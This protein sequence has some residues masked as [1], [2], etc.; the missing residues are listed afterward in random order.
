MLITWSSCVRQTP[1][2]R[3]WWRWTQQPRMISTTRT[4]ATCWPRKASSYPTRRWTLTQS[5]WRLRIAKTLC[6]WRTSRIPWRRWAKCSHCCILMEKSEGIVLWS[7]KSCWYLQIYILPLWLYRSNRYYQMVD[8]R[9]NLLPQTGVICTS[10][11]SCHRR[12]DVR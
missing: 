1:P 8:Q 12:C 5:I 10:R 2:L 9:S 7:I 3:S 4:L 11:D 6:S